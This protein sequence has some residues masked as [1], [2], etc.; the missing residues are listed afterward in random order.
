MITTTARPAP[1]PDQA[2]PLQLSAV[3]IGNGTGVHAGSLAAREAGDPPR[4]VAGCGAGRRWRGEV[5]TV[6]AGEPVSE[7]VSCRNCIRNLARWVDAIHAAQDAAVTVV[8][9]QADTPAPAASPACGAW[10]WQ[11]VSTGQGVKAGRGVEWPVFAAD[12]GGHVGEL[13]RNGRGQWSAYR[14]EYGAR[15]DSYATRGD[16]LAAVGWLDTVP[17]SAFTAEG[18]T[19]GVRPA[20]TRLVLPDGST[21]A[22]ESATFEHAAL[23]ERPHRGVW[24]PSV[25]YLVTL[26]VETMP[27]RLEW[28]APRPVDAVDGPAELPG[29]RLRFTVRAGT[30]LALTPPCD[31]CGADAGAPCAF[32]CAADLL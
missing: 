32:Q 16:A 9:D 25:A 3:R 7:R 23:H 11:A 19:R 13:W 8:D 20:G 30:R 26:T 27:H 24:G 2:A 17:A 6:A 15:L 21:V 12:G 14:R 29:G 1:A 31:K 22:V 28:P 4:Y 5:W 18:T 10:P